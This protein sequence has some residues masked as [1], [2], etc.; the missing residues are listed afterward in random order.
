MWEHTREVSG[1]SARAWWE[2]VGEPAERTQSPDNRSL[3]RKRGQ[4]MAKH[5]RKHLCRV[6]LVRSPDD[7]RTQRCKRSH[8]H[9]CANLMLTSP[10]AVQ[11]TLD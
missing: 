10:L 11:K 8:K 3:N 9:R 7:R 1:R 4:T 5:A 2:H 6:G